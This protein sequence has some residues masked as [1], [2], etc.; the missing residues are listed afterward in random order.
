MVEWNT[1][2]EEIC[3][4]AYLLF[5]HARLFVICAA[6]CSRTIGDNMLCW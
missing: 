5:H 3:A 6:M 2:M 1:G 4:G